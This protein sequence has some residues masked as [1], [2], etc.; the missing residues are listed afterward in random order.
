[1]M[2]TEG[3]NTKPDWRALQHS[4]IASVLDFGCAGK[5]RFT[6]FE[7]VNGETLRSILRRRGRL[8]LPEVQPI[9]G[10][11]ARALDYAHVKGIVHRDLKPENIPPL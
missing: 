8:P 3:L 1:M 9:I 6:V 4:N 5:F 2:R 11:V 7:Y 10:Q